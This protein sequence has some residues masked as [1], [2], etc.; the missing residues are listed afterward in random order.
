MGRVR[1]RR[2]LSDEFV[3]VSLCNF[4]VHIDAAV[5]LGKKIPYVDIAKVTM[6]ETKST[7]TVRRWRIGDRER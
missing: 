2:F 3:L 7:Y 4:C 6:F 5:I 1:D